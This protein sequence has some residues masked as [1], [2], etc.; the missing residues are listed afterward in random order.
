MWRGA[1]YSKR[2]ARRGFDIFGNLAEFLWRG[3]AI[4]GSLGVPR[5]EVRVF[6]LVR[7]AGCAVVC[8]VFLRTFLPVR[9]I[10]LP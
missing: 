8:A 5:I 9:Y 1:E 6:T 3:V 10:I 4:V 2:S 7:R